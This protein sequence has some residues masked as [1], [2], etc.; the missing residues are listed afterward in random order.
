METFMKLTTSCQVQ[1]EYE[2]G[3]HDVFLTSSFQFHHRWHDTPQYP[4]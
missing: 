1:Y 2:H 3:K 4:Y